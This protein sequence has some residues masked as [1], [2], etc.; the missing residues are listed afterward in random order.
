MDEEQA[1]KTQEALRN[2][3][4]EAMLV[5][6]DGKYKLQVGAFIQKENAQQLADELK[7]AGYNPVV[8]EK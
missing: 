7:K 6:A 4:K 3:G 5:P 1:K 8:E 2:Q